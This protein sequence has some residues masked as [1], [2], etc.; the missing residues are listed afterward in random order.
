VDASELKQIV[1][2]FIHETDEALSQFEHCFLALEKDSTNQA[3]LDKIFR[4][5]H[6]LKGSSAALGFTE[7]AEFTHHFESFLQA[8]RKKDIAVTPSLISILFTARDFLAKHVEALRAGKK[9]PGKGESI[10]E[11]FA[12]ERE[13]KSTPLQPITLPRPAMAG[14]IWFVDDNLK[15]ELFEAT[16]SVPQTNTVP[17][18]TPAQQRPVVD[19]RISAIQAEIA[20]L[21]QL[22]AAVNLSTVMAADDEESHSLP[23]SQTQAWSLSGLPA[24]SLSEQVSSELIAASPA[25]IEGEQGGLAPEAVLN[26]MQTLTPDAV[27]NEMQTLTPDAVLNEMQ[28]LA[29]ENQAHESLSDK[30][31]A[32]HQGGHEKPTQNPVEQAEQTSEQATVAST[33]AAQSQTPNAHPTT[34]E[35]QTQTEISFPVFEK[36]DTTLKVSLERID[37]IIN[38]IEE[39]VILQ[40]VLDEHKTEFTSPLLQKSVKQMSK[41]IREVQEASMGIRMV[42]IRPV[43]LK[44]QRIVRETSLALGKH[45]DAH[46]TGDDTEL[47][48]S[49]LDKI[50]DPLTHLVRN[51]L[52]HGLEASEERLGAGKNPLGQIT[53]RA[54]QRSRAIVIEVSDDGRGLDAERIRVK[55][56]ERGLIKA[57]E[58]VSEEK[59]RSLIFHPGFSTKSEVT[60]LSGRGVGLDVVSSNVQS[61][62]GRIEVESSLGQGTTFRLVLP[63][64]VAVM[65]GFIIRQGEERYVLAKTQITETVRPHEADVNLVQG[66]TQLLNLRGATLPLYHLDSLLHGKTFPKQAT[67]SYEGI[68]LV[69]NENQKQPFAVVVDDVISQQQV[70]IKKLGRELQGLSGIGGAAILG[71]GK[72]AIILDLFEL[73]NARQNSPTRHLHKGK[74]A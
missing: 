26:E 25:T 6:K 46:F 68:A 38:C 50:G 49:I 12:K 22:A 74:V 18:T 51:A 39:L 60:E 17:A 7:I 62:Q 29:S 19:P 63:L 56:I 14:D 3:L 21:T 52:D 13:P 33:A 11:A 64:T 69:V 30:Q 48:K 57:S 20:R 65:D 34:N 10:I 8:L 27:L 45:V 47:D 36:P 70:V 72:P 53:I 42:S 41:I 73:V 2:I 1:E 16:L 31:E 40:S 44:L 37:K 23:V 5:A 4:T 54:F 71:D 24:L 35:I 55:A 32:T 28:A 66:R 9:S 43:F 15:A 59:L 67:N 58:K 61:L